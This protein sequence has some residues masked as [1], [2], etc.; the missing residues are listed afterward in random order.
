MSVFIRHLQ[1]IFKTS[2]RCLKYVFT[3]LQE[4][5]KTCWRRMSLTKILVLT[6]TSWRR[7]EGVFWRCMTKA[8]IFVLLRRLEDIFWRRRRKT[9]SRRFQDVFIKTNVWW[10]ITLAINVHMKKIHFSAKQWTQWL[11]KTWN[12]WIC[13]RKNVKLLCYSILGVETDSSRKWSKH[14]LLTRNHKTMLQSVETAIPLHP[15]KALR[16]S[17]RRWDGDLCIPKLTNKC[18][19]QTIPSFHRNR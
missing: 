11:S 16:L 2:W 5:L 13:W 18:Q 4:V 7:L 8:N 12:I 14:P 6:K 9:S 15:H 10:V 19:S 3:F 1:D 17:L